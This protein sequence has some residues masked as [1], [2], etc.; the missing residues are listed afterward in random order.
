MKHVL[1]VEDDENIC[2][3]LRHLFQEKYRLTIVQSGTEAVIQISEQLFDL[4]ILDL[5]LPGVTGESVL[6]MIKKESTVPVIIM[7]AV[8]DKKKTVEL[9]KEGAADYVTKPFDIDELEA[10]VEVQLRNSMGN[11]PQIEALTF[12]HLS[13]NIE[14]YEVTVQNEKIDISHK[15]YQLLELLLSYPNKIYSKAN[16]YERIWGDSYIGGENTVNVH[17]STLRKKL[18]EADPENEYIE[19]VWGMG[20]RLA[21]GEE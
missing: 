3:L 19:T 21:K 6:K 13:L 5:M 17:I 12:K 20:I 15:E 4:V 9:L 16:L 7:T 2:Q 10:R 8:N 18:K 11:T 1:I 14:N